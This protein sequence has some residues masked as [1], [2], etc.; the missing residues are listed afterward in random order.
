MV[1]LAG[2]ADEALRGTE[3]DAPEMQSACQFVADNIRHMMEV[4][5]APL[6]A[7]SVFVL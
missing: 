5:S 2:A 7:V 3:V 6:R 1:L 4:A